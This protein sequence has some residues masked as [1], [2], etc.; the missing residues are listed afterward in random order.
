MPITRDFTTEQLA[1]ARLLV[2]KEIM[3]TE[4]SIHGLET[5]RLGWASAELQEEMLR[6]E[7]ERLEALRDLRRALR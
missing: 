3:G 6:R 7:R 5:R 4:S 1:E 2:N